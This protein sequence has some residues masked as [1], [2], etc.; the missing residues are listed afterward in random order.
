MRS[1]IILLAAE[2]Q[3]RTM[4]LLLACFSLAIVLSGCASRWAPPSETVRENLGAVAVVSTSAALETPSGPEVIG[5]WAG[6]KSGF[7]Q[8]SL[9]TLKGAAAVFAGA[10]SA[11][12]GSGGGLAVLAGVGIAAGLVVLAPVVGVAGSVVG[13]A[14]AHSPEEVDATAAELQSAVTSE[15]PGEELAKEIVAAAMKAASDRLIEIVRDVP[16]VSESHTAEPPLEYQTRSYGSVLHVSAS[17]WFESEG[18][19]SPDVKLTATVSAR[20]VPLNSGVPAYERAWQYV[21]DPKNY[22][23]LGADGAALLRQEFRTVYGLIAEKV[24]HDLFIADKP[25]TDG[26]SPVR[27]LRVSSESLITSPAEE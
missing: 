4:R 8:G 14:N 25:G 5:K 7:A 1:S 21:G 9:G 13:A 3:G 27:T 26:R 23:M 20:L 6:A 17:Y 11:G 22:F 2:G 12:G 10:G 24:V 18:R 19:I 15:M 16:G